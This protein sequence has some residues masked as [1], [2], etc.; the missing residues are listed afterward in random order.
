MKARGRINP[1]QKGNRLE[2]RYALYLELLRLEGSVTKWSFEE[3][4]FKLANGTWY[5][6]DFWV[7][8]AD[9]TIEIH[10][11]KGFMREAARVRI[12]VAARLR[13]ELRF[14]LVTE[15]RESLTGRRQWV[16]TEVA[17]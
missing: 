2:Q 7:Q 5:L 16:F 6:P 10:E 3:T 17:T 9:A 14:V 8:L 11:C 12:R 13:P 4:K 15:D 1:L